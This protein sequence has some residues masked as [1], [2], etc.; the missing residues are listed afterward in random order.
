MRLI[1]R[2]NSRLQML[3]GKFVT[4]MGLLKVANERTAN[5]SML[6]IQMPKEMA[7]ARGKGLKDRMARARERAKETRVW[8]RQGR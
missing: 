4:S 5:I 7:R 8:Q 3:Q 2:W 6:K 1:M